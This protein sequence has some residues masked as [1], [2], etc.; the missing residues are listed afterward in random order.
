MTE[1]LL[2]GRASRRR[3][4]GAAVLRA[5]ARL[6]LREPAGVF[7]M[8]VFPT[9]LL[10][11]LGAVPSFRTADESLGGIRPVDAY[12][13][14]AG[15]IALLTAGVAGMPPVITGYRERGILRRMSTTPVRPAALLGAQV[16]LYGAAALLS[17]VVSLAVGRIVFAVPL[18]RQPLG[19]LLVL[20]LAALGALALGAVISAFSRTSR[21]AGGVGSAV[22]FPMMFCAGTWVPVQAMPD[23]LARVVGWTPFGAAARAFG[24][25]AAGDW[26]GW[27]HLGVLT[28]WVAALLAAAARWFRW[29]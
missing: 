20:A 26:P 10:G 24:E 8:L 14:V 16:V 19:H 1:N 21:I 18:P 11:I 2:T 4:P 23:A 5:E 17:A 3:G 13:P 29:E 7:W 6:F 9:L 28:A 22:Y 15:L 12:T 25:A 27:G